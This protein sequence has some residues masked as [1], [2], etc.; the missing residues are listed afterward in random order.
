MRLTRDQASQHV[1]A[2]CEIGRGHER[3]AGHDHQPPDDAPERD[4]PES[5]LASAETEGVGAERGTTRS[6]VE[7]RMAM[8][9][10]VTGMR[11]PG[12][13]RS[14]ADQRIDAN[15]ADFTAA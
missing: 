1:L 4:G 2:E 6:R 3:P 7:M 15:G 12:H 8:V 5:N 10:S 13:R 14:R 9:M 11:G